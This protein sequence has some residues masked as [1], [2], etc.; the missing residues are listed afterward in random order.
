MRLYPL[1]NGMGAAGLFYTF[2]DEFEETIAY[3]IRK[4][5]KEGSSCFDIGTNIG[6]WSLLMSETCG[7][8]GHVY[9]FE[10]GPATLKNLRE[11]IELS[12]KTNITVMPTALGEEK[13]ELNFYTP[14]DPG[15]AS[16]AP[17]APDDAVQKVTVNRLDD[18]WKDLGRPQISFVK[19]DVEGAEPLVLGGGSLFFTQ[20]RPVVTSEI[21]L[22]KLSNLGKKPE[23]IFKFFRAWDYEIFTLDEETEQ[24]TQI[25]FCNGGDVLFVPK[26]LKTAN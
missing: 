18:V 19:M 12:N 17:E 11:N 24:L 2:R 6:I 25:D 23:D 10:P 20:C 8:A 7:S 13:G 4:F 26:E 3:S 21:N 1:K 5:V 22:R 16:L 14:S 9:S 15:R